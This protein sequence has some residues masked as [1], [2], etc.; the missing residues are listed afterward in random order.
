M[1][2]DWEEDLLKLQPE[3]NIVIVRT[4][5][6]S[7]EGW[8]WGLQVVTSHGRSITWGELREGGV[9]GGRQVSDSCPDTSQV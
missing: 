3:E 4:T 9:G 2:G 6:S 5:Y 7:Q 1:D 8:L